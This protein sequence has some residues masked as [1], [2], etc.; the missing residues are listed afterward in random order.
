MWRGQNQTFSPKFDVSP[1][2]KDKSALMQWVHSCVSCGRT[3][4]ECKCDEFINRA[5][6]LS[7]AKPTLKSIVSEAYDSDI[8][9]LLTP[10]QRAQLKPGDPGSMM[11]PPGVSVYMVNGVNRRSTNGSGNSR[12]RDEEDQ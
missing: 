5:T 6:Q 11:P 7:L 9:E 4:D 3:E 12:K 10:A 2:V 1:S 8:A